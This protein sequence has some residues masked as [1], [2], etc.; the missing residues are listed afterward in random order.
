[1][2]TVNDANDGNDHDC[3]DESFYKSLKDTRLQE[4]SF[5]IF[6][7]ADKEFRL[8]INSNRYRDLI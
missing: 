3:H 7:F 2:K 4:I 5:V 6:R 1:M 8:K